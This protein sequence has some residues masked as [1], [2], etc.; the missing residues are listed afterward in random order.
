[1]A[2]TNKNEAKSLDELVHQ[3]SAS[4]TK[5]EFEQEILPSLIKQKETT[6]Q[7]HN[8]QEQLERIEAKVDGAQR[9][10]WLT[11]NDV[12]KEFRVSR[13]TVQKAIKS[14]QLRTSKKLGKNMFRR[15]W[16]GRWLNG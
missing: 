2:H 16:V 10:N 11:T 9:R 8:I 6:Y 7:L 5:K 13:S 15:V 1:M 4:F 14:G 12:V 3:V